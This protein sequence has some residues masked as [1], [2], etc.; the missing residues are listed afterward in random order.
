MI[1]RAPLYRQAILVFGFIL[2]GL[3]AAATI[4]GLLYLKG[5]LN[6]SRTEKRDLFAKNE[7]TAREILKIE[8]RLTR[9][10]P[11]AALWAGLLEKETA[12]SLTETFEDLRSKLPETEFKETS[13]R[14]AERGAFS[15]SPAYPSTEVQLSFRATYRG[16]QTA[17][18]EIESRLPQLQLQAL[19]IERTQSEPTLTFQAVYTAWKK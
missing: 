12:R 3:A 8:A 9:Q 17:F 2:P 15:T 7:K 10:R 11:L 5:E 16:M 6:T 19:K 4:A 1:T 18:L 13:N 14:S